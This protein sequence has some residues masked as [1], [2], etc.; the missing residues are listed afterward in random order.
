MRSEFL[1][2]VG[3]ECRS[4]PAGR[5][6]EREREIASERLVSWRLLKR[7]WTNI[8]AVIQPL[9][10]TERSEREKKEYEKTVTADDTK[11][12]KNATWHANAMMM[13]LTMINM[14]QKMLEPRMMTLRMLRLLHSMLSTLA[15]M[16]M[17]LKMLLLTLLV[18]V[19]M[20]QRT[21]MMMLMMLQTL[22][23][24][25]YYGCQ[26]SLKNNNHPIVSWK[27]NTVYST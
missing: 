3:S 22:Q 24:I 13:I 19:K 9:G 1:H 4:L 6:E 21:L 16:L 14:L 27:L 12:A 2:R 11:C 23:R 15:M 25:L 17:A 8:L 7:D 5:E 26:P 20:Q 18:N 10:R